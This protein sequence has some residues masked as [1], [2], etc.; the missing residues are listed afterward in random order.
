MPAK[1]SVG[2]RIQLKKVH[3]CGSKEWTVLR[4]GTT[5]KLQC[6]GCGRFVELSR[7]ALE[8]SLQT[9]PEKE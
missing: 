9:R 7:N 2:Q 8:K 5:V 6:A 1:L 4:L 3:P